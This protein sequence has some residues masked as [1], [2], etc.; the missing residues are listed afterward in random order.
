MFYNNWIQLINETYIFLG[1]CVALNFYYFYWDNYGNVINSF[2]ASLF[3][4]LIIMFPFF[5][6]VYYNLPTTK[7]KIKNGD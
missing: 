5:V 2:C 6:I 3:G 4:S 1:L 7:L